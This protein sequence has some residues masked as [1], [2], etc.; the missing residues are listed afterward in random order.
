[1]W[2]SDFPLAD[3]SHAAKN[4]ADFFRLMSHVLVWNRHITGTDS[5][6]TL[7]R[8][9]RYTVLI[10]MQSLQSLYSEV[11]RTNS[12]YIIAVVIVGL[13]ILLISVCPLGTF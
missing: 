10:K 1:M 11:F 4:S 9:S 5:I 2:A 8:S 13:V 7:I 12:A 6:L 3:I